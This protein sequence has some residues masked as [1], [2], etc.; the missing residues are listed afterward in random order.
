MTDSP[1]SHSHPLSLWV[2]MATMLGGNG[3]ELMSDAARIRADEKAKKKEREKLE[4]KVGKRPHGGPFHRLKHMFKG[5]RPE[6][7]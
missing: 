6:L 2:V 1:A 5:D 3:T 4:A 7:L